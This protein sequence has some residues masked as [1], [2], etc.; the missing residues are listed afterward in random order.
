MKAE[1]VLY[2]K[3]IE[4]ETIISLKLRTSCFFTS[5]S[6]LFRILNDIEKQKSE[7]N[8]FSTFHPLL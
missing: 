8:G 2:R 7:K 6:Y 4:H 3:T 5:I 1:V